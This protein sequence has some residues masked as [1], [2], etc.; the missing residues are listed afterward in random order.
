[1]SRKI[2]HE[3]Q[4]GCCNE[5][6]EIVFDKHTQLHDPPNGALIRCPRCRKLWRVVHKLAGTFLDG[7]QQ[8]RKNDVVPP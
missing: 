8:P 6:V 1:M 3:V 4:T 2:V 7:V 5:P